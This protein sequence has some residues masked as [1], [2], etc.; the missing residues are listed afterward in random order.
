MIDDHCSN[1]CVAKIGA[2]WG[3]DEDSGQGLLAK[4]PGHTIVKV[5]DAQRVSWRK[6]AEPLTATW[7]AKPNNSGINTQEALDSFRKAL[8][9]HNAAY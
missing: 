7:L 3:N 6:A 2:D 4:T 8:D 9:T 1:E 5:T